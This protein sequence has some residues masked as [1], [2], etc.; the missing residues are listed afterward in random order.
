[1]I[2]HRPFFFD[3]ET[4]AEHSLVFGQ[5]NIQTEGASHL[6]NFF[7]W[8][9]TVP[10]TCEICHFYQMKNVCIS[11]QTSEA[12]LPQGLYTDIRCWLWFQLLHICRQRACY[13]GHF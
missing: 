6:Y 7:F 9:K 1:M 5:W 3:A 12:C 4:V 13:T 10:L 8:W 2:V 11:H